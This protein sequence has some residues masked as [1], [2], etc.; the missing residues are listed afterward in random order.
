MPKL[1][2]FHDQAR[3]ALAHGVDQLSAAV[4]VTLGPKG[5]NV[6]I[7]R[8]LGRPVVSS[9]GVS[10]ANEIELVDRFEN[11]GAQLVRE[12]AHQTNEIAGD[13]TTTATVLANALIQRGLAILNG[14]A[15]PVDL[16]RG[17]E[18]AG[19]QTLSMLKELARPATSLETLRQVASIAGG[20]MA[21]G[22]LVMTAL[23]R[24]GVDGLIAVE[25]SSTLTSE[26]DVVE[27]MQIDRGYV[28][29]HMVTD[30]QLMRANLSDVAVLVTDQLIAKSDV[31]AIATLYRQ[32]SNR[33][34][35]MLL[36]ADDVASSAM[37]ELLAVKQRIP[38]VIVRAPEFGP[39]R[40]LALEDIAIFTGAQFQA[41]DLGQTLEKITM[42]VLGRIERAEIT[43]DSA[44]L[45]GGQGDPDTIAGRRYAINRQLEATEQPFEREK[46]QQRLSRLS[47][48]MAAIYVGGVTSVDQKERMQRVEDALHAAKAAWQEGIV[49][50]GGATL[51]QLSR[52][53]APL[54]ESLHGNEADG[55]GLVQNA[56]LEPLAT[57]ARN[58]GVDAE[59]VVSRV[60][61]M[62]ENMG[63]DALLGEFT[64][65]VERGIVDPVKVVYAAV[66]NAIAV[67]SMILATDVLITDIL[68]TTDVTEGP[69]R[70]GGGELLGLD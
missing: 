62:P 42:D 31:T 5:R 40:T 8:P 10:I 45:I 67:S 33:Y 36:I 17:M 52:R 54:L 57:I 6:M 24:V 53:L 60:R 21:T 64:D 47:G 11:M 66:D 9:D 68:D 19:R 25:P 16:V 55:A 34:G 43:N 58:C 61:E 23:E 3:K 51:A 56:L 65:L 30:R 35:A 32:V 38:L 1:L 15:N 27:G 4:A 28:S 50:G 12:V 37:A 49:A 26:V 70:G 29:H 14:G 20:D 22:S 63:Y 44:T 41:K 7:D 39:W 2:R 46:L 18:L 69:A 48:G 59:Q 13:G